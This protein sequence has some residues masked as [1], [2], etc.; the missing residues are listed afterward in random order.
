MISGTISGRLG[1]P[2]RRF[3][4]PVARGGMVASR[5]ES[6]PTRTAS[7]GS[8]RHDLG[9]GLVIAGVRARRR[10]GVAKAIGSCRKVGVIRCAGR[11]RRGKSRRAPVSQAAS[12]RPQRGHQRSG[13]PGDRVRLNEAPQQLSICGIG[14]P[15]PEVHRHLVEIVGLSRGTSVAG[16]RSPAVTGQ[17]ETAEWHASVN[18]V[19]SPSKAATSAAPASR[20]RAARSAYR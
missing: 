15:S 12:D 7:P 18:G 5:K 2:G 1:P 6:P 17:V 13:H 11:T 10:I 8:L 3:S 19:A 20:R 4:A 16:T 9:G 14:R